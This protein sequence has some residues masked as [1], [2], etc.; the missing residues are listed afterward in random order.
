[1]IIEKKNTYFYRVKHYNKKFNRGIICGY[2]KWEEYDCW[3]RKFTWKNNSVFE[4]ALLLLLSMRNNYGER[5]HIT[6]ILLLV[7]VTRPCVMTFHRWSTTKFVEW[8]LSSTF[9]LVCET[10]KRIYLHNNLKIAA[11]VFIKTED[12]IMEFI[13]FSKSIND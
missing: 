11:D 7:T 2:K 9:S 1:M 5:V 12:K 8:T 3:T 6:R 4:T 10:S 13:I